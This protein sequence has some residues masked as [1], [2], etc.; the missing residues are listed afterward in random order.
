[1]RARRGGDFTE[2]RRN[3]HFITKPSYT[4]LSED[5]S[6][7]NEIRDFYAHM[8]AMH[9]RHFARCFIAMR[10]FRNNKNAPR[11]ACFHAERCKIRDGKDAGSS[12]A[13]PRETVKGVC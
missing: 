6:A 7:Q 13:L 3:H 9:G 1:M 12:A 5:K 10:Y 11:G 2:F 8:L 4:I